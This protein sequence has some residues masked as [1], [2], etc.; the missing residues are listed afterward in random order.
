MVRVL[1]EV[2]RLKGI[3]WRVQQPSMVLTL[4][5]FEA[6][7]YLSHSSGYLHKY[8]SNWKRCRITTHGTC[9]TI[10]Q[11][12]ATT[13]GSKATTQGSKATTEG[14]K[15]TTQGSKATT[16]GSYAFEFFFNCCRWS[17]G[18]W[19]WCGRTCGGDEAGAVGWNLLQNVS[20]RL[21]I[22]RMCVSICGFVS[23]AVSISYYT[24][25]QDIFIL[26]A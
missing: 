3:K 15:A 26:R 9:R 25:I 13:Q 2:P 23:I 20:T 17:V 7:K 22:S 10:C 1:Q 14:S 18:A 21:Y 19:P 12:T 5:P 16:Q 4:H 24:L 11:C 6:S 8:P